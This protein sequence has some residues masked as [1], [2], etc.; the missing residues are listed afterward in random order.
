MFRRMFEPELVSWD[1]LAAYGIQSFL[2][3][4]VT[5][6]ILPL[7]S[8]GITLLYFDQRIQKEGFGTLDVIHDVE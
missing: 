2:N 8:I 7:T 1:R 3:H 4:F 5:S 6:L